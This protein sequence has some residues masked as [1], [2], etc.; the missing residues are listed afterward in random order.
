MEKSTSQSLG[1][2]TKKMMCTWLVVGSSLRNFYDFLLGHVRTHQV[3]YWNHKNSLT[4]HSTI[5]KSNWLVVSLPLPL[6]PG[7]LNS[8]ENLIAKSNLQFPFLSSTRNAFF[9]QWLSLR[10]F[11]VCI[12]GQKAAEEF[13]ARS[14]FA[15]LGWVEIFSPFRANSRL[16]QSSFSCSVQQARQVEFWL[17]QSRKTLSAFLRPFAP[18]IPASINNLGEDA[19]KVDTNLASDMIFL[20]LDQ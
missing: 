17:N 2:I 15:K 9:P 8:P 11:D 7:A 1:G 4:L 6:I 20:L 3:H 16:Q 14:V 18:L 13:V 5:S 19:R 10:P 12:G